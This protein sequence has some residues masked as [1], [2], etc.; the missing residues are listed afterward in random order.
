MLSKRRPLSFLS[1]RRFRE[2]RSISCLQIFRSRKAKSQPRTHLSRVFYSIQ[3]AHQRQGSL[4]LG[5]LEKEYNAA[6][7]IQR[8]YRWK[9]LRQRMAKRRKT[10]VATHGNESEEDHDTSEYLNSMVMSLR[11]KSKGS[12]T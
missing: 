3:L 12:V 6:V 2:G 8:F 1:K 7:V 10:I 4:D 5:Q 9:K 11:F